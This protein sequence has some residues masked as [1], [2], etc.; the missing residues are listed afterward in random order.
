M[1]FSTKHLTL[2]DFTIADFD[3]FAALMAD[4]EVMRFSLKG[5]LSKE[6]A[7]E[8]F[9]KRVI[10]HYAKYGFGLWA[11]FRKD[12]FIGFAGLISQNVDGKEEIELAFR[13][14]PKYW[15][16]GYAT[17]AA[18]EICRYAFE[19]LKCERLISIVDPKN[20]R[21]LKVVQR[22]GMHFWKES[23]F[24]GFPVRVFVIK[25]LNE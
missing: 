5:P 24:Y 15:G 23:I 12:Q 25:R 6:E 4:P 11:I 8:Y 2:R 9:Q 13:L 22:V 3:V 14:D 19:T 1:L 17:E 10:D 21:S 20:E 16:K 7:K 18:K